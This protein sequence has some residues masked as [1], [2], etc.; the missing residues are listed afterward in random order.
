MFSAVFSKQQLLRH[1]YHSPTLC[2]PCC[3]GYMM[4]PAHPKLRLE[5]ECPST[6]LP[7]ETAN[8]MTVI[9]PSL[10]GILGCEVDRRPG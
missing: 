4:T 3:P 8:E 2:F 10:A 9:S 1:S 6:F 7:K 5:E